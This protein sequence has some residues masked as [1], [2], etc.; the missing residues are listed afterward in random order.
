M[1]PGSTVSDG[2]HVVVRWH[3]RGTHRGGGLSM[4]PTNR[5]VDFR[6]MT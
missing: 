5:V 6:G 2:D 1:P 3:A 4:S